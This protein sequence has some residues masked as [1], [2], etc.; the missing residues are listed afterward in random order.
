MN[1]PQHAENLLGR[2]NHGRS[3]WLPTS[4]SGCVWNEAAR[5]TSPAEQ[6]QFPDEQLPR[7]AGIGRQASHA[8]T[9]PLKNHGGQIGY[10]LAPDKASECFQIIFLR[11]IASAECSLMGNELTDR[12]IESCR[13]YPLFH[14]GAAKAPY[15][16]R[17]ATR[18]PAMQRRPTA[19]KRTSPPDSDVQA[20]RQ[21]PLPP[22]H[23]A[24]GAL[25]SYA[26][27]NTRSNYPGLD[28]SGWPACKRHRTPRSCE[29]RQSACA[30]AEIAMDGRSR[31]APDPNIA[32]VH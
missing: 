8:L 32:A 9:P 2:H 20:N 16:E 22:R 15:A 23:A 18:P 3:A 27:D 30:R 7:V 21:W 31:V 1:G 11:K 24:K 6:T 29:G 14:G 4:K 26:E 12:C 17:G 25:R 10:P 5:L 13:D 19:G 28:R